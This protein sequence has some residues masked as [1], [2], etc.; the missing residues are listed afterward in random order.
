MSCGHSANAVTDT[1]APAC[2]ICA[3]LIEATL[4][5]RPPD[6]SGRMAKC[7][8]KAPVRPS[9]PDL[10]F[11]EY[12]GPGSRAATH[13]RH[14]RYYPEAHTDECQ[15]CKGTGKGYKAAPCNRCNGTGKRK[16]SCD[17]YEPIAEGF[18][19]DSYY[20]GHSGWD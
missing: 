13:C 7:C 14:C 11:F 6:L 1:G 5:V 18:E 12:R 3:P 17:H 2:A 9:S 4:V 19:H 15:G 16:P 8:D 20:C 10:A